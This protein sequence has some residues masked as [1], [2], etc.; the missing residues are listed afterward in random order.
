[1]CWLTVGLLLGEPGSKFV[2]VLILLLSN[3]VENESGVSGSFGEWGKHFPCFPSWGIS[4][5]KNIHVFC[6]TI[7]ITFV[8]W[9]VVILDVYYLLAEVC[10]Q[11]SKIVAD[12]HF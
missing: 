11:P 10:P 1:M 12:M 5:S 2:H 9:Y 4:V 3:Q 6:Y 8:W 7:V